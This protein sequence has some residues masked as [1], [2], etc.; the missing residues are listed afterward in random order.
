MK[1]LK[2]AAALVLGTLA[3]F[4]AEAADRPK[5]GMP[6][7]TLNDAFWVDYVNFA[8]SAAEAYGYELVVT[9]AQSREDKQLS[10]IETLIN[11]GVKGVILTP[12]SEPLGIQAIDLLDKAGVPVV[13][14]DTYPGVEVGSKPNYLAF[15]KL[16]DET[17]GYNVAKHL[18]EKDG[19]K[20]LVSIG[21]V[22][23]ISTSEARNDGMKKAVAEHS[24][25]KLLDVQYTD[26]TLAKGQT[27]ME[28]FLT[29][30]DNIDGVWGAGSDPLLGAVVS[31]ENAGRAGQMKLAGIDITE[32]AIGAL[33]EGKLSMLA[34]GH[35]VMGGYGVTIIH[36]HLNGHPTDK[37]VYE[38]SLYY[39]TKDGIPGYRSKI[40]D[41]LAA[42]KSLVDW[43]AISKTTNASVNHAD[44][45]KVITP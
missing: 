5:I 18:I 11:A 23:G 8:K 31:I 1:K 41:P 13:V 43:A 26:W 34:G 40:I 29:R 37:P 3:A 19:V 12:L 17:A 35:W 14:T 28:D 36:D 6:M 38:M 15:I 16:D 45:F 39:L 24:D 42:G 10:D 33:D 32:A 7:T 2:F 9:D 20:N 30:F 25:V 21:G 4:T 27:V 22:P 44:V